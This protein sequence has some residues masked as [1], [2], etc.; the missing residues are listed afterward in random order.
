MCCLVVASADVVAATAAAV[1]PRRFLC[2]FNVF[3]D[4]VSSG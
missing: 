2:N 1:A 3:F 4:I